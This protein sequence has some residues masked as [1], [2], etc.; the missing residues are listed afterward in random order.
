MLPFLGHLLLQSLARCTIRLSCLFSLSRASAFRSNSRNLC[1]CSLSE[2]SAS[3]S[4]FS[5]LMQSE[6]LAGEATASLELLA[7]VGVFVGD[8]TDDVLLEGCD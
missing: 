6:D 2:S 7:G 1:L 4:H 3:A 8:A 5:N